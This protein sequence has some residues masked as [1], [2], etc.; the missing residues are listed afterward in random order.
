MERLMEQSQGGV[1]PKGLS[2]RNRNN[3]ACR[4]A[5]DVIPASMLL[6]VTK[7]TTMLYVNRGPA[8]QVA[9]CG[10]GLVDL[11]KHAPRQVVT[12]NSAVASGCLMANTFSNVLDMHPT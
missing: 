2:R 7:C 12:L 10:F 9:N 8:F 6:D 3:V 4:P 1:G 5:Q 11:Q